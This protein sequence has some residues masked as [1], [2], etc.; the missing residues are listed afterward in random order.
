MPRP[1]R[2]PVVV[3]GADTLG[4]ELRLVEEREAPVG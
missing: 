2:K 4:D 3:F 1:L